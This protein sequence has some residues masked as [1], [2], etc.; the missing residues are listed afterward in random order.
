MAK[1]FGEV[2]FFSMV[3][4][5]KNEEENGKTCLEK[6]LW[7]KWLRMLGKGGGNRVFWHAEKKT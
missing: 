6:R 2:P 4:Y 5:D 7:A 1:Y 3:A